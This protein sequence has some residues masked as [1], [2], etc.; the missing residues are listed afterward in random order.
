MEFINLLNRR[1]FAGLCVAGLC[2]AELCVAELCVAGHFAI[3]F[4]ALLNQCH[5]RAPDR[6]IV[7][8]DIGTWK[9]AYAST[10]ATIAKALNIPV[11][12]VCVDTWLGTPDFWT[13]GIDDPNRGKA[14]GALGA[15]L[16]TM[17]IRKHHDVIAPLPQLS[18]HAADVLK[19]HGVSADL[20]YI[21][22]TRGCDAVKQDLHSYLPL[23]KAGG[24]ILGNDYG[25]SAVVD[26]FAL[27]IGAK[28]TI[29]GVVWVIAPE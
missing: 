9:G 3:V 16:N 27:S 14:L 6:E 26:E 4:E 25:V 12:I 7:I 1:A 29:E 5:K 10:M 21:D 8:I 24:S 11:K 13:T 28:R 17:F 22:V 15:F 2:V 20:I 23:L 18:T 19:F